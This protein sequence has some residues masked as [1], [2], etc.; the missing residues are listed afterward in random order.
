[1][2]LVGTRR[3]GLWPLDR[4]LEKFTGSGVWAGP[5]EAGGCVE[6]RA[7]RGIDGFD[8]GLEGSEGRRGACRVGNGLCAGRVARARSPFVS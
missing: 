2:Q 4:L 5:W 1:M 7:G 3:A 8:G 6:V